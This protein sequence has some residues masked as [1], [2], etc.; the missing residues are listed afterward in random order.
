MSDFEPL[1]RRGKAQPDRDGVLTLRLK[2]DS[3]ALIDSYAN[4]HGWTRADAT[5]SLLRAGLKAE[6]MLK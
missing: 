6:G 4:K 3:L 1:V 5:R 2:R